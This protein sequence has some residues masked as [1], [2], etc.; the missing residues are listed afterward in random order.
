M[1]IPCQLLATALEPASIFR[2]QGME[3]DPWQR[4]VLECASPYILL[5]CS[6]GAGKTRVLTYRIAY[7]IEQGIF[8]HHILALTF[9]NKA[10]REMKERVRS[11]LGKGAIVPWIST[12]HSLCAKILRID[13]EGI[14][15]SSKFAIYD[16]SDQ[17]EALKEAMGRLSISTKDF[18][19][20]SVHA[21]ISQAKN[22]LLTAEEY[23]MYARGYFQETVARIYPVYQKI[24]KKLEN[25]L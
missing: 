4:E 6:R 7:L 5:N 21:T 18:K 22:E 2:V 8:P 1:M 20:F 15:F 16:T 19:P 9:T 14:G 10:A 24:L 23:P 13:G 12:F 11:I 25:L 17:I 3:A